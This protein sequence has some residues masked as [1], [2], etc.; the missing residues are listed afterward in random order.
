MVGDYE[1]LFCQGQGAY[2]I[3]MTHPLFK[4]KMLQEFDRLVPE[5]GITLVL[6]Y[7]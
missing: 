3:E 7:H 1:L 5:T 4:A 6:W 2:R